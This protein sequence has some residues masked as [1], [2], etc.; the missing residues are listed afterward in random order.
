MAKSKREVRTVEAERFVLRDSDGKIRGELTAE[1]GTAVLRLNDKDER[2]GLVLLVT[3]AGAS[4]VLHTAQGEQS[5]TLD[6][7]AGRVAVMSTAKRGKQKT[8][9]IMWP[10]G[11]ATW[12][13]RA[14]HKGSMADQ[15]LG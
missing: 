5:L 15:I 13:I 11:S 14:G 2:Q 12:S 4:V 8:A 3:D 10:D 9:L 6:T 1:G 7:I